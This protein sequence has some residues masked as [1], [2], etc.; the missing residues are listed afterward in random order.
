MNSVSEP[1][2]N[3]GLPT[4]P[5][6]LQKGDLVAAVDLGS[7]SFHAVVSRYIDG[8]LRVVDRIKH[9]V[10]LAEGLEN[11]GSLS[12]EVQDRA[13]ESLQR[14]GDV[15]R[16][17]PPCR[18]RVVGTNTLRLVRSSNSFFRRAEKA[19]GHTIQIISGY[20]EARLIFL[21]VAHDVGK[22]A[23]EKRL[24]ID[25]G[26]GSTEVVIGTGFEVE[27]A[28][29]F[30]MGCVSYT[31]RFFP[32]QRA[33]AKAFRDAT[34]AA[35]LE[36]QPTVL[37]LRRCGWD[38]AVGAS[39]TNRALF[40]V[41]HLQNNT[42]ITLE[43][44]LSLQKRLIK[45]EDLSTLSLPGLSER[46][47][48][49]FAAGLAILTAIFTSLKIP[50]MIVSDGALREGL[51]YDLLGRMN[52]VDKRDE[53]IRNMAKR[54]AID[55]EH[56]QH[57]EQVALS[58]FE[59]I[60]RPW[61]LDDDPTYRK[62]LGWS[63]LIHE[64][65]LTISHTHYHKHGSYIVENSDMAGFSRGDQKFLWAMVR[66]HRKALKWFRFDRLAEPY[67][68]RAPLLTIALRLAVVICR[69]RQAEDLPHFTVNVC[70]D[71]KGQRL[72]LSFADNYLA[73]HPLVCEDLSLEREF[74]AESRVQLVFGDSS[75][76]V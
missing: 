68:T 72:Q 35:Q 17:I 61:H 54:Y 30:S 22:R 29:S 11:D 3:D 47:R 23:N 62:M 42:T 20:E 67:P 52:Q 55:F 75:E 5:L 25:I 58:I 76:F 8:S 34:V 56:A 2:A 49:V 12:Q 57:V 63:A 44:L 6:S 60:K 26:G 31:K 21:G 70:E 64:I 7:N 40:D 73:N 32:N 66:S 50:S 19:L 24:V 46:R 15:I 41:L 53:T 13:I 14:I 38:L 16:S 37:T 33:T 28:D 1:E 59:A 4:S 69:S 10:R 51:L 71:K 65:G 27:V 43:G 45:L 9:M 48:P 39:G 74:L 18:V 36:L